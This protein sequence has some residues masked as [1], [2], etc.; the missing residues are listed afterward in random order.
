MMLHIYT[1][2]MS[3]VGVRMKMIENG[4]RKRRGKKIRGE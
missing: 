1:L 2:M 4:E 3:L